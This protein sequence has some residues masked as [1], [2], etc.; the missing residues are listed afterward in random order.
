ML[1]KTKSECDAQ[2][3]K[4][5]P[6]ACQIIFF[7]KKFTSL[8]KMSFNIGYSRHTVSKMKHE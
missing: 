1:T 3:L 5:P 8:S 4:C 2:F 6:L 7:E